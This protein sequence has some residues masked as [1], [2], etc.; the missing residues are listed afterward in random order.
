MHPT[1]VAIIDGAKEGNE[2]GT[3]H[4]ETIVNEFNKANPN[5]KVTT[6]DLIKG[7]D[8]F[9]DGTTS[10]QYRAVQ[11]FI[12]KSW[13][14]YHREGG[15]GFSESFQK[16]LDQITQAF[17]SVYKSI[18]GKELT[19]ELRKMFDEILGKEQSLKETPQE[20]VGCRGRC[21]KY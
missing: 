14:K 16:V 19:P 3:K 2:V 7:N 21:G 9:K 11:E 4:T 10:K 5:N 15:K 8:A 18:S 20:V 17:K 12:A 13:E 6:E 1:V